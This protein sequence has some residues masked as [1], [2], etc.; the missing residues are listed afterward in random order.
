MSL[1]AGTKI[2]PYEIVAPI[3]A[4]GMGEV[5]RARDTR[6]GRE[7]ALKVLPESFSRDAERL[8]RFEQEARAVAALNHPNILAIHDIGEANGAPFLIS[9]LLEG[10]SLRKELDGGALPTRRAVDYGTQLANGLAAAHDKGIVHRDLKPEN[11]FVCLDGRIKI[12]DFGLAKLAKPVMSAE[13]G[14]TQGA[15]VQETSPGMVLGTVGYMSPE[16][17]KGEPADAR[18]DIFSLGTILYEMFSGQRAFRRD[19]SAETMTAIL[20]EDPPEI[21]TT[22]KPIAPAL[23][24]IVRRCL[25]KKPLQRFQSARDLAF[26][27]EGLS[28]ATSTTGSSMAATAPEA[29]PAKAKPRSWLI[30]GLAGFLL[31]VAGGAVGWL[32]HRGG[33][34]VVPSFQQL[35]FDRGLVYGAR[36]GTDG[37]TIYYSASWNGEPVQIYSTDPD[38]PESR[39][40]NLINSS[41]FA[42]SRS[43]I[44]ISQGCLDR[45]IGACQGTLATVPIAGGAPRPLAEEALSADWKA[46]GSEMALVRQVNGKYRLEF[47]RGTVIYESEH[48]LDYLRIS[49]DG[50]YAAVAEMISI[51]GDA[52]ALVVVDRT[53]KVVLRTQNFVS[54]E[55]LAWSPSG[56]EVWIGVT[57]ARAGW[58]DTI[59]GIGLSGKRRDVYR[60]P[61][62]L[63]LHDV[64]RDGRILFTRESW[65]METLFRG[66]HDA[67]D[68]DLSWL[69]YAVAR[70]ISADGSLVAFDDWGSAAGSTSL[71][72][73]RKTDGSP[74]VKLGAWWL[75]VL[76]PDGQWVLTDSGASVNSGQLSLVPVG[77][78]ESRSLSTPGWAQIAALGWMPDGKSV[79]FVANLKDGWH[80][81]LQDLA[82]GAPKTITPAITPKQ[83]YS[84][85]HLVSPDGKLLF[86]RDANAKPMLYPIDGGAPRAFPGFQPEDIWIT[87]T[88]DGKSAYVFHDAKSSAPVYRIQ[89]ATGKRELVTTI[90]VADPAG[91]TSMQAVR[92]TPDG[93]SYVYSYSR[94]QSDLFVTQGVK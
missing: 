59:V 77:A 28:G 11:V 17:V 83:G 52:G 5:Y 57:G 35:T 72:Y 74:A 49:P 7:V 93:K 89:L 32:L 85:T 38:S 39:P 78:G 71:A 88:A 13:E 9:E 19:T 84:E 60:V 20:K 37:R 3:G 55:G 12:L 40:L 41:L 50:K 48:W 92:M 33:T 51:D 21:T 30:P 46:D 94:E 61:G 25:E 36:F 24:R 73:V 79:Y 68:R 42:V 66:P 44:A 14:V 58:A 31:L 80:V 43:E 10:H 18:S 27:L 8:R 90:N 1:P 6:L 81:W 23:E 16:Q 53:G 34:N 45:F 62:M 63:R 67:K 22:G 54:F 64:T 65:R 47:P 2:G 29:E 87:W 82:G 26:N 4:G 91:V 75:P 15:S 56:D 69:D 70:D 86:A 76:S